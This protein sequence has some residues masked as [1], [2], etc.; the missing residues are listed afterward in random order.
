MIP[1]RAGL[2][3]KTPVVTWTLV[4][5]NFAVWVYMI[6]RGGEYSNYLIEKYGLI[7]L[8]LIKGSALYTIITS[9][10]IHGSFTHL[11]G[12]MLYLLVFGGPLESRVGRLGF[13]GLYFGSGIVASLVHTFIEVFL[14]EPI[15]LY[16]WTGIKVVDPRLIPAVGASGAISGIL[17]AYL[18]LLPAST[19]RI[20]TVIGWI[21]VIL[22]LPA[23]LFIGG[24]FLYQLYS[25]ILSLTLPPV[26][27]SGVAFWAHIGGFVAGLALGLAAKPRKPPLRIV[28]YE[29]GYR[30]EP[31]G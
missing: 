23:T 26:Y 25:G 16:G 13:L 5:L 21:P 30:L 8:N 28:V 19:V 10:F 29:G 27:F 17:G 7:P 2:P 9:M 1:I 3:K 18:L 22:R 6:H 14:S 4:I 20:V 31:E 11:L 24:W 12:N 15:I